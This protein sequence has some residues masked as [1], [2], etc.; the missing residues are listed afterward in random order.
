MDDFER[1]LVNNQP[2]AQELALGLRRL[3]RRLLPRAQ[4]KIYKG[5]G[6]ADYGFGAPS[7]GFLSIGPQ[8]AYVNLYFMDGVELK[9]PDRLLEC[10]G[11]RL[12]HVKIMQPA[13]LKDSS[14][15]ALIRQAGRLHK[16]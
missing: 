11:K 9:D 7:R 12:R 14:L 8:K 5:W 3:V 16:P 4:E 10:T 6:V 1:L 15:H 2:Q 13:D